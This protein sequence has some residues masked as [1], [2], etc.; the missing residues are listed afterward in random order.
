MRVFR[1]KNALGPFV[2]AAGN[3]AVLGT[4]TNLD[5][6]GLKVMG[7]YK[8]SSLSTAYMACGH[9][10][11][12][13]DDDGSWYLLY[14][15]RFNNGTEYHEVRV[16]Q[17]YFNDDGWPVVA[18]Y[19]Y[20]GN[21]ISEGGYNK[22][23]I[24]GSYEYINHGNDT[25][26]KIYTASTINL[27]SDGTI[28]GAVSGTWEEAGDS[29]KATLTIG[30]V[31]YKGYFFGQYDETGTGKRVMTFTVVGSNNCTIWGAKTTSWDGS[32]R[33]SLR[34]YTNNSSQTVYAPD[35]V[36]ESESGIY[37]GDTDILSDVSYF[38]INKNSGKAIDLDNGNT[39]DGTN[40][41]QWTKTGGKQQEWRFVDVGDGYFKIVSMADEGKCIAVENATSDD[42]TNIELQAYSGSSN[43]QWKI[44]RDGSYYAIL[45]RCS[46]ELSGMD[47]YDW[48][49][50]NGGNLNQWN[51]WGGDCQL[52]SITPVYPKVV[53]GNYLIRNINSCLWVSSGSDN[54]Q[55]SENRDIWNFVT[56]TDGTYSI[57]NSDGLAVTVQ[58]SDGTDGNNLYLDKYTGSEAQKFTIMCNK[59]GSYSILSVVSDSKSGFD[60]YNI[61]KESGARICQWT[62][63]GGSGQKFILQ[64][65]VE[66]DINVIPGDLNSD[67]KL[68][69]FDMA[70]YKRGLLYGFSDNKYVKKASDV[71]LD[72]KA[73]KED[74]ILLKKILLS[75]D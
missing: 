28:S 5:S 21:V 9:N 65:A 60:V 62:F 58:N 12:L 67:G 30:G 37:I 70:L 74:M 1:S 40:I 51:Y 11:V 45:S 4:N 17:M 27:N 10:S 41:Q 36:S 23:T 59:D 15:A 73:D 72:G 69:A 19:E 38:I 64:P 54:L 63:W 35:T 71:N 31:K 18:P 2:D 56:N 24:T 8:F 55:Q 68:N 13:K 46:N 20:S 49:T 53:D 47:I 7:N 25:G 26:S 52:W 39:A 16:H 34:D 44:A 33:S 50:E 29:A 61:S 3:S 42:G 43:Q 6:I 32:E 14:H 57:K 22:D 75:A 48:S 66:E